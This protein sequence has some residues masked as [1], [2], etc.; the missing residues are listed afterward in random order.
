MERQRASPT[1]AAVWG[2]LRTLL[3]EHAGQALSI[4][5]LDPHDNM[6]RQ[7]SA[8]RM[9]VVRAGCS[10]TARCCMLICNFALC[11]TASVD[12]LKQHVNVHM[13]YHAILV[14]STCTCT[15]FYHVILVPYITL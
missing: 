7:H 6:P 8:M 13:R 5:D 4:C 2:F 10:S 12:C 15:Y 9:E 1:S 3:A 11:S 14:L